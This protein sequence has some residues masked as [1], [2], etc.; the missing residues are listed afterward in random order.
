MQKKYL[1][2]G[3]GC[4]LLIL[5]LLMQAQ[6]G[7]NAVDPP[8]NTKLVRGC[9]YEVVPGLAEITTIEIDK[10]AAESLLHYNEHKVL[11]KFTPMGSGEL[12]PCLRENEL[13]FT[14]RTNITKIPVGPQYIQQKG[15]R[16]GTKYAMNILQVKDK[17]ACLDQYTYESKV[18]DNDLFEAETQIIP[19]VKGSYSESKVLNNTRE[20]LEAC[21][22]TEAVDESSSMNDLG[23]NEDSL[24]TIIRLEIAKKQHK[25]KL[26]PQQGKSFENGYQVKAIA[27]K[28][29]RGIAKEKRNQEK[30]AK[31]K[32]LAEKKERQTKLKALRAKIER[33]VELEIQEEINSK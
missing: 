30:L 24:R 22:S 4:V 26:A 32:A 13:E 20:K 33:E 6:R 25:K 12:L 27:I 16:V 29:A 15:M 8:K 17:D 23:V 19:F 5:P 11:F 9:L 3:I 31:K 7:P 14:L 2:I 28:K 1:G 10:T 18:L 21:L